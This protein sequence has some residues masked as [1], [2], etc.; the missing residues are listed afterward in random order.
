MRTHRGLRVFLR[1]TCPTVCKDGSPLDLHMAASA[2]AV[3]KPAD[4]QTIQRELVRSCD[5]EPL[6]CVVRSG[7]FA[8]GFAG[9]GGTTLKE[10]RAAEVDATCS[11]VAL[12]TD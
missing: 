5:A 6:R 12:A 11:W 2:Y 7:G 10:S 9:G 4:V 3:S 1:A 8:C